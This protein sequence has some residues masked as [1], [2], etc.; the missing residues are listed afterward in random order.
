MLTENLHGRKNKR[1]ENSAERIQSAF[2]HSGVLNG[3][4]QL[5]NL[6]STPRRTKVV[7][8]TDVKRIQEMTRAM[9]PR[10]ISG[11]GDRAPTQNMKRNYL[12]YLR[13]LAR[14]NYD[15]PTNH[16]PSGGRLYR[17]VKNNYYSKLYRSNSKK[18]NLME[19]AKTPVR[20]GNN[21]NL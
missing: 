6:I 9:K 2:R 16:N 19:A 5:N 7:S 21:N 17:E 1:L 3:L 20:V 15:P 14:R 8:A 12:A 11:F 13:A 4:K 10:Y 18:R